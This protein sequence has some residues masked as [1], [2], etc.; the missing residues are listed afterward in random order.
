MTLASGSD[1]AVGIGTRVMV[2]M[3]P[4]VER[5][6]ERAKERARVME[7]A[8]ARTT[9]RDGQLPERVVEIG[10]VVNPNRLTLPNLH[11]ANPLQHPPLCWLRGVQVISQM[12]GEAWA[13][14]HPT[15]HNRMHTPLPKTC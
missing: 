4:L 9:A 8:R 7:R 11:K 13:K 10:V 14:D 1:K 2:E 3:D 15:S 12:G 5:G 6:K